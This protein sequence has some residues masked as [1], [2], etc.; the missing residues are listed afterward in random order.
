MFVKQNKSRNGRILLTFTQGYWK[1]GKVK[2]KNIETIGYLDELKKKYDDPVSH[3][4]K[5][6]KERT[7]EDTNELLI[8]NLNSKTIDSNQ[9]RK[10]LGYSLLKKIYT[11]LNIKDCLVKY[12]SKTN[13]E[14]S[15]NDIF[16]L[17]I[18]SR[19][20]FPGSK[21][22]NFDNKNRFFDNFDFSLKDLYRS[23]DHFANLKPV[24]EK[25]IWNNTKDFYKRDTSTVY[26][27][28]TNYYF[29]ISYN[30]DDLID[31]E[32]NILEKGYRKKGPSKENRPDPIISLGL[33]MDNNGI[34]LSYT[35]FP[36]NESEKTTL[37]PIL[38]DSKN[39]F[40]LDRV[41]TVADRGLNTSDNTVFIAGK[42][43]DNTNKDGYIFGQ[44]VI[45]AS[46][47]FKAFV[48]SDGYIIDKET[49]KHGYEVYFKHKSR[50]IAKTTQIKKD[51]KRTNKFDIYQKQMIYHSEKY[52][53]K[54]KRERD[55]VIEKAKDL[56]NN[57]GKYNKATSFGAA[58][59]I[60]NIKYDKETGTIP[61]GLD[62]SLN[63]ERINELE[64][65]DGYYSIVTSELEMS[66]KELRDRYKGLWEIEETFKITKSQIKSRPVY[67]WTKEHIE[68]HF[69]TCFIS[70]VIIRLLEKRL[71]EKYSYEK[72]IESLRNYECS[73]L[74]HDIY[75]FDYYD[76]IIKNFEIL[77]SI[78]LSKKYATLS[79]VKKLLNFKK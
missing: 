56:I 51:G 39:K 52:A 22:D 63:Q 66:D 48:L 75:F 77:F 28:C 24:I 3:F 79:T 11:E 8:K 33:L 27:D 70:L 16:E 40:N 59:F 69:L 44:S 41:I 68:A 57:P 30:D 10:N 31:E 7:N 18:Y 35:L 23:L 71:D 61:D 26:Y 19:I 78:D 12:Q 47:E 46:E 17:L 25:A 20:L 34:P 64:K 2:H 73:N 49:D 67:V 32:G 58:S 36:G 4:K 13:I 37:R 6:A 74:E 72:I 15:L 29:E 76:S 5:I 9:I 54:Q 62:L 42:N 21:K 43:D 1:D 65:Y 14:Y 50:I 53:I 55:L 38:K 45:G 60:N